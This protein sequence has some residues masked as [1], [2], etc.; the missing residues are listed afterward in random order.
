MKITLCVIALI[1]I[2]AHVGSA[3][4]N[5]A[6]LEQSKNLVSRYTSKASENDCFK[7]ALNLLNTMCPTQTQTDR[8]KL[9]FLFTNCQLQSD[10][11]RQVVC[12]DGAKSCPDEM[13]DKQYTLFGSIRL[14][15][16]SMCTWI[17]HDARLAAINEATARMH[18]AIYETSS[19]IDRLS[20]TV[21]VTSGKIESSVT[22]SLQ[23]LN[24]HSEQSKQHFAYLS[25]Q[26]KIFSEGQEDAARFADELRMSLSKMSSKAEEQNRKHSALLQDITTSASSLHELTT[27]QYQASKARSE[28]VIGLLDRVYSLLGLVSA[29]THYFATISLYGFA[30][31]LLYFGSRLF[32]SRWGLRVGMSLWAAAL[33]LDT[34]YLKEPHAVA[35]IYTFVSTSYCLSL[36]VPNSVDVDSFPFFLSQTLVLSTFILG[37]TCIAT[38]WALHE[39][40]EALLQ[41]R[42]VQ[43]LEKYFNDRHGNEPD[44]TPFTARATTA[45]TVSPSAARTTRRK[46]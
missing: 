22:T 30:A 15:L 35:S 1:A 42:L 40:S 18:H 46:G 44:P 26:G 4:V 16:D 23:L 24:S 37:C 11:L 21:S 38:G 39:D 31:F 5:Y 36:L 9:A 41:K 12:Y 14:H 33:L 27:T 8:D 19:A 45:R 6:T 25:E 3:N 10:G 17:S 7:Q 2:V 28:E 32:P 43:T 29:M 20:R 34:N 13:T